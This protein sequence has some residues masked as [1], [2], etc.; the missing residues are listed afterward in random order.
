MTASITTSRRAGSTFSLAG[1][2]PALCGWL[3][4]ERAHQVARQLSMQV[5]RTPEPDKHMLRRMR[6]VEEATAIRAKATAAR[7]WKSVS[8]ANS[9]IRK[10]TRELHDMRQAQLAAFEATRASLESA[11]MATIR[12]ETIEDVE[13]L[14]VDWERDEDGVRRIRR[15]KAVMIE[16]RARAQR[17]IE[18]TGL[19]LAYESG[20]LDGGTVSGEALYWIGLKYRDAYEAVTKAGIGGVNSSGGGPRSSAS[21]GPADYVIE[22]ARTLATQRMGLT[23]RQRAVLDA[24]CGRDESVK[25]TS[26]IIKAGIPATKKSLVAG[27]TEAW[28]NDRAE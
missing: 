17:V 28:K 9:V 11:V 15:G 23:R 5:G 18:R 3:A 6:R 21:T 26:K 22:A 7:D 24:V 14:I 4:A 10:A 13:T 25:A 12:G 8:A 20:H 2:G 19:R 27:L 1:F 16:D